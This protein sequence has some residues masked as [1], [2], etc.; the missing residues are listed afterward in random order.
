LTS[1]S[2]IAAVIGSSKDIGKAI[3]LAFAKSIEVLDIYSYHTTS[4][5]GFRKRFKKSLMQ[6]LSLTT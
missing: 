5:K 4:C 1:G 3:L 6:S 2:K